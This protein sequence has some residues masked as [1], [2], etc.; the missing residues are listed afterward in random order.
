M[1]SYLNT[2]PIRVGDAVFYPMNLNPATGV[3][4]VAVI[5]TGVLFVVFLLNIRA[6]FYLNKWFGCISLIL[7]LLPGLLSTLG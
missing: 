4:N 5:L 7:W 1:F 2:Q 3:A 6:C